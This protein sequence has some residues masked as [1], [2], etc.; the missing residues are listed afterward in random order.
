VLLHGGNEMN[1]EHDSQAASMQMKNSGMT[2]RDSLYRPMPTNRP[3]SPMPIM[4]R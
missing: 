1:K 4:K 2:G 3:N